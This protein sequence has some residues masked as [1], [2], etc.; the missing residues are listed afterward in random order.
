MDKMLVAVFERESQASAAAAAMNDLC[1]EHL[2]LIYALAVIVKNG[3]KVSIMDFKNGNC[4]DRVL[5]VATR[6][7][8]KLL[9]APDCS[10]DHGN[11]E[12]FPGGMMEMANAGVDSI[13]LDQVTRHL[14]VGR[15]AIVSEVEEETTTAM[16]AL[17]E[18]QGGTVF[19][20]GRR[21]IMDVQ[22]AK[23][24]DALH[25][26]IQTLEMQVLQM[27]EGSREQ[28]EPKLNRARASFEATKHRAR[29]HAASIKREAEAKIVLLQEQIVKANGSSKARL[30]RLA[31]EIR[32]EY[33]NRATKLNLAWQFAADVFAACFLFFVLN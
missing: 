25:N 8:I 5:R 9:A 19:R 29:Q 30:E 24:L 7:L 13:F 1:E 33:V 11:S 23:E 31:D 21:E 15:A 16:D 12:A 18:S 20:C 17:L 4:G 2:L 14:L 6:S 28:L 22:I 26:E 27:P 10:V 32:V 3:G